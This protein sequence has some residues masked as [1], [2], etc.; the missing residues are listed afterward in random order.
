MKLNMKNM[1]LPYYMEGLLRSLIPSQFFRKQLQSMLSSALSC[2][3]A[4]YIHSRVNYY[5][6]TGIFDVNLKDDITGYFPITA[7]NFTINEQIESSVYYFDLYRYLVYFDPSVKFHY[8]P[9]DKIIAPG[10]PNIVKS[11]PL[12][13]NQ[14]SVLMNLDRVRHFNFIQDPFLYDDKK[15][16]SVWRGASWQPHRVTMLEN[17]HNHPLCDVGS[18]K[19][20]ENN[21]YKV[22]FMPIREQLKY[23]FVLCPE[24]NDVA[25]NLKWVM[26]SNS[27]AVMSKPKY[28]TWFMEGKLEAGTH[29]IEV[30]D[31]YSNVAE[32]IHF[33]LQHPEQAKLISLNANHYVEQFYDSNKEDLISLMVLKKYFENSDQL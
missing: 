15:D 7:K 16:M 25:T 33:Y 22:D 6:K 4:E 10:L 21:P 5:N 3:D 18:N 28:E 30:K 17:I 24:G 13:D 1:K 31:D 20:I 14:N 29:Y 9:G 27:I 12:L 2:E 11:R 23:K 19:P 8:W 26:S 32:K